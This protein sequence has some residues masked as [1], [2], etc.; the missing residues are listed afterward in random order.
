MKT[1]RQ[2]I[3]QASKEASLGLRERVKLRLVM[4]CCPEKLE[5]ELF[6]QAKAEGKIPAAAGLDD[7]YG[8]IDWEALA[9]FIKEVLPAVLQIIQLFL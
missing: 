7:D 5:A 1:F 8:E 6:A 3:R 2:I 4:A 9:L